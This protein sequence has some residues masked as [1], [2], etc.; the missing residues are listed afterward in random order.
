MNYTQNKKYKYYNNHSIYTTLAIVCM[1]NNVAL[2]FCPLCTIAVGA[3]IGL[4]EWLGIDDVISGLWIGGLTVS[5]IGWTINWMNRKNIRFFGR[6]I[7]IAI[8]YYA[9]ILIPL[10]LKDIIGHPLNTIWG[11]DK[12]LIGIIVGSA[13]FIIA[14]ASYM[15]MK[16]YNNNKPFFPLQKVFMPI[17]ALLITSGIFYFFIL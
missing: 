7:A 11:V 5:I 3:G 6:K 13:V 2:A 10:Y 16:A 12:L 1:W 14:T 8:I 9:S 17:I 4:A 15:I